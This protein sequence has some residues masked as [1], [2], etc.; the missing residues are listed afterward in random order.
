MG[1]GVYGND[2]FSA[3]PQHGFFLLPVR[4]EPIT[5]PGEKVSPPEEAV[6]LICSKPYGR[7]PPLNRLGRWRSHDLFCHA[8]LLS[9]KKE[10]KKRVPSPV[11]MHFRM[12]ELLLPKPET[13]FNAIRGFL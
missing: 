9:D 2:I 11:F 8:S 4:L 6:N 5:T 10:S 3:N 13:S 7:L 1:I 12:A